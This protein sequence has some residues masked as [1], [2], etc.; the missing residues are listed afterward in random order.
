MSWEQ[1]IG[2]EDVIARIRAAV[3]GGRLHPGLIFEGSVGVGKRL[4][5]TTLAQTLNCPEAPARKNDPCGRC[6]TCRAILASGEPDL[7]AENQ[8]AH[9]GIRIVTLSRPDE[10]EVRFGGSSSRGEIRSQITVPQIR[11]V[12]SEGHSRGSAS[13]A[14]IVIID[15]A[16]QMGDGAANALLKTLEEPRRNE[17]FVLVT[18]RAS[19]LLPT[20]RSR[21]VSFR[22]GLLTNAQVRSVLE[23]RRGR[24]GSERKKPKAADSP[25]HLA[26]VASLAGGRIGRAIELHEGTALGSYRDTRGLFLEPLRALAS[27]LPAGTFAVL[28]AASLGTRAREAWLEAIDVL[29]ILLRD[30]AV[31]AVDPGSTPINED[32]RE[33]LAALAESLGGHAARAIPLLDAVRRDFRVNVNGR[34]AMERILLEVARP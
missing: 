30:L 13:G 23:E 15:P 5:A 24:G 4:V 31:L 2:H 20:I 14:R 16:D 28:G 1:I 22:F 3:A 11:V 17:H 33:S 25:D 26:L 12:L 27:G 6:K 29:E 34:L 9:P 21:A 7:T 32:I 10:R 18:A 8:S 19:A